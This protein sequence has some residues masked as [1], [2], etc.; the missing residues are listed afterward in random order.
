MDESKRRRDL[1]PNTAFNSERPCRIDPRFVALLAVAV[2]LGTA[3]GCGSETFEPTASTSQ[4]SLGEEVYG[5]LCDRIAADALREDLTGASFR[6]V[7]HRQPGGK[8]ADEV[9]TS[10]LPAPD[11]EAADASGK[12]VSVNKQKSDRSAALA[13]VEAFARRR[14]EL[15]DAFDAIIPTSKIPIKDVN[16]PNEEM[17]CTTPKG[18]AQGS[19]PDQLARML[20]KMGPLYRD[21]TLADSTRSLSRVVEAF[22]ASDDAQ[23]AWS[24]V[25]GRQGYRPA[26]M[27]LGIVRPMA[28]YPRLRDLANDSLRLLSADSKPYDPNASFDSSGARITVPGPANAA[29]NQLLAAGREELLELAVEPPPP[30]MVTSRDPSERLALSRPREIAEILQHLLLFPD[31]SFSRGL[32]PTFIVRRDRRGLAALSGGTVASPF[33]DGNSDGLPDIDAFGAFVSTASAGIASPFALAGAP[34]SPRDEFGRA[35]IDGR[36]AYE[37]VDLTSTFAS[38]LA[39]DVRTLTSPSKTSTVRPIMD[40][41]AGLAAMAGPRKETS[42]KYTTGNTV[43]YLGISPDSPLLDIAYVASVMLADRSMDAALQLA[44]KLLSNDYQASVAGATQA[45]SRA[46]D[47]AQKYPNAT[48]ARKATLWDDVIDAMGEIAR[49]PG[50]LED[51]LSALGDTTSAQLGAIFANYAN[52]KDEL[53]YNR[54]DI[55]GTVWNLSTQSVS[56]MS[57]PVDRKRPQSGENRSALYRFLQTIYDTTGVT[58][59]NKPGAKVHAKVFNLNVDVP[60][61]GTFKECEAFKVENLSAFYLDAITRAGQ[62]DPPNKPNKRGSFYLRD[63]TLRDGILGIGAATV[64]L[65]ETSSGFRGFWTP[66][67][68]RDLAPRPEWLNRLVFF[69]V[70]GDSTNRISQDFIRDLSGEFI[71]TSVCPTREIADPSPGA[72]DASPDGRVRGLRSCADGQWLQQRDRNSLFVWEKYG[73]YDAIRPIL[74]AFVKRQRE[75]LFLSLSNALYKHWPSNDATSA[76][77]QLEKGSICPRTGLVSYEPFFTEVLAGNLIGALSTVAQTLK[78]VRIPQCTSADPST[79]A[80]TSVQTRSGIDVAAAAARALLDPD[81]ARGTMQLKDRRGNA[82]GKRSDGTSVPQVTPARLLNAA[83]DAINDAFDALSQ[84]SPAD[85]DR[86]ARW[87]RA[88]SRLVD[89]FFAVSSGASGLQF[90]NPTVKTM[91]PVL[92]DLLRSQWSAHCSDALSPPYGPCAWART[93]LHAKLNRFL[94]GPVFSAGL[95]VL[96]AVASDQ[97]SGQQVETFLQYLVSADGSEPPVLST[98]ASA[99]DMVQVLSDDETTVPLLRLLASAMGEATKD[100]RG[101]VTEKSFIDAQMALLARISGKYIDSSGKQLCS[102]EIDPNQIIAVLLTNAVAPM[103]TGISKGQTPLDVIVDVIADVNRKSLGS[104]YNGTLKR[105]DYKS[106][107]TAVIEFL[108]SKERGLEQFYEIIRQGVTY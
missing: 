5:V 94:T 95:G 48:M 18:N 106:V 87:K 22:R 85:A 63:G 15:I 64:N 21:G 89:H 32:S 46:F 47:T 33:V 53:T 101:K 28:S 83:F 30:P 50:L 69:D 100:A 45:L 44:Q 19:L 107:S 11:P 54:A 92:I 97:A 62:F 23:A 73:F 102:R 10:L 77:C 56:E 36:L 37:Y 86:N 108:T 52:Y 6:R 84:E 105:E 41:V 81:Y 51:I 42:K 78:D 57:T 91:G 59:C 61:F 25:S 58:A 103:K 7:C 3:P 71:G 38:Q 60:L 79:H 88:R 4:A 14:Q 31:A 72:P 74:T 1:Q 90:T 26:N 93:D 75:D 67:N 65:M 16:N 80:C 98:L 2:T 70:R 43:K 20:G 34:A 40:A 27:A 68:S 76:E 82:T 8:F 12:T 96:D 104:P 9:D 13:R 24:R 55:N 66:G 39:A 29:L 49:E 99:I 35:L 17:S